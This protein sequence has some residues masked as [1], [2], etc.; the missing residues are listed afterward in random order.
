M[1]HGVVAYPES[2]D[3]VVRIVK[4]ASKFRMPITPYSGATNL[5]GHT[6]GVRPE[7]L[8]TASCF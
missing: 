8:V 3:D 7:C 5:E 2:T 6:R 1:P 4:I